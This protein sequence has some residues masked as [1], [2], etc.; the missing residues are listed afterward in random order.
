MHLNGIPTRHTAAVGHVFVR[1]R[2][3]WPGRLGGSPP[4]PFWQL[5]LQPALRKSPVACPLLHRA[6]YSGLWR[7]GVKGMSD[8]GITCGGRA[9]CQGCPSST[10]VSVV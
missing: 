10:L 5:Q 8:R 1:E 6:R 2:A 3:E 4:T 9:G 7:R